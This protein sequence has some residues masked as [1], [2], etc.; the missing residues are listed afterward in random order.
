MYLLLCWSSCWLGIVRAPAGPSS[1]DNNP[2]K[3]ANQESDVG[4]T[5]SKKQRTEDCNSRH[6]A[7]DDSDSYDDDDFY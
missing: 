4:S 3:D 5:S 2:N 6:E 1:G 7:G